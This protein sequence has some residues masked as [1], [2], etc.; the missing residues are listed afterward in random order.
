MMTTTMQ[1]LDSTGRDI[2]ELGFACERRDRRRRHHHHQQQQKVRRSMAG[3]T[4][5][6][7]MITDSGSRMQE[8]KARFDIWTHDW[9]F[10]RTGDPSL[11][12]V[13]P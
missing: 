10:S 5:T 11:L 3:T 7:M 9:Q 2:Q 1:A 4:T 12:F 6:V 13:S 8:A